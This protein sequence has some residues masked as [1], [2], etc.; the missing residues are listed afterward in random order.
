M[1]IGEHTLYIS[2]KLK[3]LVKFTWPGSHSKCKLCLSSWQWQT[4]MMMWVFVLWHGKVK[5]IKSGSHVWNFEIH[6]L[7]NILCGINIAKYYF[8]IKISDVVTLKFSSRSYHID[9]IFLSYSNVS[10]SFELGQ[11]LIVDKETDDPY[12]DFGT[13]TAVDAFVILE[14]LVVFQ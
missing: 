14:K 12:Y 11:Y 2:F 10:M 13:D 6:C 1:Y 5:N 7:E 4:E 8:F 9:R 3:V